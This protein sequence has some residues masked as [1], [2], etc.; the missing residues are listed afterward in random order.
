MLS[1]SREDLIRT[2]Y[3]WQMRLPLETNRAIAGRFLANGVIDLLN[4]GQRKH[5][6]E[7]YLIKQ[8]LTLGKDVLGVIEEICLLLVDMEE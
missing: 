7:R 5:V 4:R 8:K 3:V 6:I 2:V 1:P